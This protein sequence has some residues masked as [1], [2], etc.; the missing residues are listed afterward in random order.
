MC[1]NS[2]IRPNEFDAV[3]AGYEIRGDRV[4]VFRIWHI[5]IASCRRCRA[6]GSLSSVFPGFRF[7]SLHPGLFLC[8]RW[9]Q[10]PAILTNAQKI[11]DTTSRKEGSRLNQ[12]CILE[13]KNHPLSQVVLTADSLT[14][15][16]CS[17]LRVTFGIRNLE[18]NSFRLSLRQ[19]GRQLF[20]DFGAFF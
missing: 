13:L 18:L 3:A 14:T 6:S 10:N 5:A 8:R 2:K 11:F 9:R 17:L 7:A 16:H 1:Q 19:F 20:V 4:L 12:F 15:A